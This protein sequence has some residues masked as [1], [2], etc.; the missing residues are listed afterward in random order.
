MTGR[1]AGGLW[2]IGRIAFEGAAFDISKVIAGTLL[3]T[4]WRYDADQ[5]SS[6]TTELGSMTTAGALGTSSCGVW[7][8]HRAAQRASM[9]YIWCCKGSEQLYYWT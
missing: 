8:E 7:V 3:D 4:A 9:L 1:A 2:A 5:V 6:P